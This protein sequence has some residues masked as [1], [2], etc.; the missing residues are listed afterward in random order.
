MRNLVVRLARILDIPFTRIWLL[1]D[2]GEIEERE[3]ER[4][5]A[6]DE[7]QSFPLNLGFKAECLFE[8]LHAADP[9]APQRRYSD[10]TPPLT[11]RASA[12]GYTSRTV[13]SYKG[14][15]SQQADGIDD[16]KEDGRALTQTFGVLVGSVSA[17]LSHCSDTG[18]Q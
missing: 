16:G 17:G 13:L 10:D 9:W 18:W 8:R 5:F 12:R 1:S 6:F 14:A 2:F 3:S 15:D 11:A 7:V 4:Q